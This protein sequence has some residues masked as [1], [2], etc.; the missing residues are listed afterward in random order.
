MRHS[1][2]DREQ[3]PWCTALPKWTGRCAP[4]RRTRA[5]PTVVA[6]P[7][8]LSPSWRGVQSVLPHR[9]PC[10]GPLPAQQ[11]RDDA[12]WFRVVGRVSRGC[13]FPTGLASIGRSVRRIRRATCSGGPDALGGLNGVRSLDQ[14]AAGRT[15]CACLRDARYARLACGAAAKTA[16]RLTRAAFL[17]LGPGPKGRAGSCGAAWDA[18][19][20]F[21]ARTRPFCSWRALRWRPRRQSG[22][23]WRAASQAARQ[24]LQRLDSPSILQCP[25]LIKCFQRNRR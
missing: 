9:R 14:D 22:A 2:L 24:N 12:P 15:R 11:C 5:R 17:V 20:G 8:I 10:I 4:C 21:G 3:T 23:C 25:H 7:R 19:P 6:G 16:P 18:R 1:T 13:T